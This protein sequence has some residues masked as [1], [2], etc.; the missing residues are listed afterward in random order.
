MTTKVWLAGIAIG[1]ALTGCNKGSS[2]SQPAASGSAP[3]ASAPASASASGS[4][5]APAGSASAVSAADAKG[6]AGEYTAKKAT[7]EPPEKVPDV[8]WKKDTG[9]KQVGP[10]KLDLK[11]ANGMVSGEGSGAL[12]DQLIAG[13]FD[14][15]ELKFSLLPKDHQAP[16]AMSGTG[17]G[18]VSAAGI[19]GTLRCAGKDGVVVREATFE[20]KG[21]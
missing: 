3:A 13:T 11:V 8:T 1:L 7:I 17:L 18:E 4:S 21:K 5:A 19:T 9:D 10:G 2:S 6:F 12:G 14:G 16:D 15:K 20:L